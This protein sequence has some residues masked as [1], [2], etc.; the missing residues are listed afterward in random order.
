MPS[1]CFSTANLNPNQVI[2]MRELVSE[3]LEAVSGG[4]T[5]IDSSID[6]SYQEPVKTDQASPAN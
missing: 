5:I 2:S 1:A 4:S 6:P 3:E